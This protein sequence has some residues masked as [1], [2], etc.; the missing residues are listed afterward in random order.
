[1]KE[2]REFEQYGK[3]LPYQVPDGFFE[4]I[5]GKT[6]QL[7]KRRGKKTKIL[8][9]SWLAVGVAASVTLLILFPTY[10]DEPVKNSV[11]AQL[12]QET[13]AKIPPKQMEIVEP[14]IKSTKTNPARGESAKAS[15][16]RSGAIHTNEP[17]TSVLSE[18]SDEELRQIASIYN[19]DTFLRESM[20]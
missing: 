16:S 12:A 9:L 1:M 15:N 3:R 6:L 13:P 14:A 10:Q 17:I 18:L 20:E 11:A 19:N 7:A 8:R 4:D 2:E 5:S